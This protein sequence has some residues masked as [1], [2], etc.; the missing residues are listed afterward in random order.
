MSAVDV[1]LLV[2]RSVE[3][4]NPLLAA[5][6]YHDDLEFHWPRPLPCAGSSYG[7]KA[8][9]ERRR[10]DGLRRGIHRTPHPWSADLA[11]LCLPLYHSAWS[12]SGIPSTRH[13]EEFRRVRSIT[14]RDDAQNPDDLRAAAR[15]ASA[16]GGRSDS[17]IRRALR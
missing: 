17:A 5:E 7:L 6:V 11:P 8:S 14:C 12:G 15:P 4:R 3:G 2:F 9:L 10:R 13:G 16:A 1:V